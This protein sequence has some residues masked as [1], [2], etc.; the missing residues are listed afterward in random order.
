VNQERDLNRTSLAKG[1]R[2]ETEKKIQTNSKQQLPQ[3]QQ[4]KT[5]R[6]EQRIIIGNNNSPDNKDK[7]ISRQLILLLYYCY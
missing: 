4:A 5:E 7:G 3:Q 1:E 2:K 6:K